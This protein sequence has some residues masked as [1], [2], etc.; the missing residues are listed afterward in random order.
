MPYELIAVP[1]RPPRPRGIRLPPAG[2]PKPEAAPGFE[3]GW[4]K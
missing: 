1:Y 4:A 3:Y 2:P